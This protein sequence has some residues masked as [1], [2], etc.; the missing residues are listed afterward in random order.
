MVTTEGLYTPTRV[1]QGVLNATAYFQGVMQKVLSELVNEI[2]L[3][4]VDDVVIWG[5][6]DSELLERLEASLDETDG[7]RVVCGSPQS[8][9]LSGRDQMVRQAILGENDQARSR[10][11]AGID[12]YAAA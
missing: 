11:R 4:W 7:A 10:A 6:S 1:P 9:F 3:V 2:C 8:G 5:N 12:G